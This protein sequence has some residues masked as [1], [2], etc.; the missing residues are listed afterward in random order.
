[1]VVTGTKVVTRQSQVNFVPRR[2]IILWLD[3]HFLFLPTCHV[4]ACVTYCPCDMYCSCLLIGHHC[5][6]DLLSRWHYCPCDGY[7]LVP[8]LFSI[9]IRTTSLWPY[10]LRLGFLYL[11]VHRAIRALYPLSS[12]VSS[13][14]GIHSKAP[15]CL[16]SYHSHQELSKSSSDLVLRTQEPFS[17]SWWMTYPHQVNISTMT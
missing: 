10:S 1:M 12:L 3:P 13:S 6:S 2:G 7:C 17:V 4:I 8:L 9:T 11:T 16:S 15:D 5:L 14:Q